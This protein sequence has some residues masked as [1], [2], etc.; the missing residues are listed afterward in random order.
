MFVANK[1][2]QINI[3]F[4]FHS[5]FFLDNYFIFMKLINRY[6]SVIM[7]AHAIQF[8]YFSKLSSSL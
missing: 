6:P 2:A 7:R 4:E 8:Y 5:P 1:F 3:R